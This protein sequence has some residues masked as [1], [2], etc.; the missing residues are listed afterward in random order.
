MPV[1]ARGGAAARAAS[2]ASEATTRERRQRSAHAPRSCEPALLR[3]LVLAPAHELRAVADPVAGDVVEVDLD[4]ELQA[5]ALPHELF[6]GLP[7]ARLPMAL[8]AGAV[9][10]EEAQQ[11][12][13]LLGLE[14]R[15]WPTMCSSSS[16]S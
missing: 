14:A 11:L 10:L 4:H 2:S 8:L 1:R 5:Q 12:A 15:V 13:L 9:G 7:A 3:L 16:S 6:V